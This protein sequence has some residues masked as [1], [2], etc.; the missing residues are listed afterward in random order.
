M[1]IYQRFKFRYVGRWPRGQ[2][3][4]IDT[5]EIERFLVEPEIV[6]FVAEWRTWGDEDEPLV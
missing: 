1:S 4:R 5:A 2:P 6:E 3:W